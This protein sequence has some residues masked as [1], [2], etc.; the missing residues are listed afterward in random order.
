MPW[1]CL[2][3]GMRFLTLYHLG[4]SFL[5]LICYQTVEHLACEHRSLGSIWQCSG[6]GRA[7]L[8]AVFAVSCLLGSA[9]CFL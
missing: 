2:G 5:P 6:M 4:E 3:Q 8:D 7:M 9:H 1:I